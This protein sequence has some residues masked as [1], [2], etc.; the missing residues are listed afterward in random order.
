MIVNREN[1]N[2]IITIPDTLSDSSVQ[3]LL[4]YIRYQ[5][6]AQKSLAKQNEVDA[7]AEEVNSEWWAKNK[8]RLL[9]K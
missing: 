3:R 7:L 1:G 8:S 6:L 4:D 9:S 2:I 5:E